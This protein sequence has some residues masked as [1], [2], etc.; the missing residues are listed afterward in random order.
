[1]FLVSIA[2]DKNHRLLNTVKDSE[3]VDSQHFHNC[4]ILSAKT[5]QLAIANDMLVLV[6]GNIYNIGDICKTKPGEASH[7]NLGKQLLDLYINKGINSFNFLEGQFIVLIV[8]KKADTVMIFRDQIGIKPLFFASINENFI[9]SDTIESMIRVGGVKAILNADKLF[10][11]FTFRYVSGHDTIYKGIQQILPGEYFFLKKHDMSLRSYFDPAELFKSTREGNMDTAAKTLDAMI[12]QNVNLR[13][14]GGERGGVMLSGGLDSLYLTKKTLKQYPRVKTY[15]LGFES[16]GEKDLEFVKNQLSGLPIDPCY[17]LVNSKDYADQ[18]PKAVRSYNFPIKHPNYVGR[19]ILFHKARKEGMEYL[20]SGDG[21]DTLF[22]GACYVS[23]KKYLLLKKIPPK[24]LVAL[25]SVLWKS[26]QRLIKKIIKTS[27]NELILY[28]KEYT[29]QEQV[30]KVLLSHF[31]GLKDPF[32]FHSQHLDGVAK[33]Q[34]MD[35]AFY[36]A[37]LTTLA[38]SPR[39]QYIMSR[40][41]GITIE[42]PFLDLNVTKFIASIP[43]NVKLPGFSAKFLLKKSV[44]LELPAKLMNRKKYGLPVPLSKWLRDKDGLGRYISDLTSSTS[45]TK[46]LYDSQYLAELVMQFEGGDDSISEILWVLINL[47]VWMREFNV[48]IE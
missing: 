32:I 10:E 1:M 19:D 43:A 41:N 48:G 33:L 36:M 7:N 22:G 5:A 28:G 13:L 25:F 4:V 26:K 34:P 11:L 31:T 15:T 30:K 16:L 45:K 35:R 38:V 14:N 12:E 21:A 20:I 24:Y 47:E 39:D 40:S 44:Q 37:L 46:R 23:L 27:I 29:S 42:Y 8:D 9:I 17:I 2:S 3:G 18:L 6:D